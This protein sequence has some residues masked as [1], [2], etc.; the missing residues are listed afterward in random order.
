MPM[1]SSQGSD[2]A[3]TCFCEKHLP[4]RNPALVIYLGPDDAVFISRKHKWIYGMQH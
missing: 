2:I 1:K 4:V 3:L